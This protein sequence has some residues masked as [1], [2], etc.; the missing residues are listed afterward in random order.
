MHTAGTC[1]LTDGFR[2]KRL[3]LPLMPA[4]LSTQ[5]MLE[6]DEMQRWM[7]AAILVPFDP[8]TGECVGG[9]GAVV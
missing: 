1:A 8:S 6:D 7:L 3:F 5:M 4:V 2:R 9:S